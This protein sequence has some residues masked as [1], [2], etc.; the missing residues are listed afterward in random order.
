MDL[1]LLIK[2]LH[3]RQHA[4][5]RNDFE[6]DDTLLE[7]DAEATIERCFAEVVR[8]LRQRYVD[9]GKIAPEL[10]Q[11]YTM[12]LRQMVLDTFL[13]NDGGFLSYSEYLQPFIPG[14]TREE[15]RRIHRT[16]FEYLAKLSKNMVK[17]DLRELL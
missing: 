3:M 14:L 12:A 10:F 15:Y 16:H 4:A 5:L 8:R 17:R 6:I 2:R 13:Q 11:N 9:P 7:A 1:A